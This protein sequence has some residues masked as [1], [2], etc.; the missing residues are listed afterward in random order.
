MLGSKSWDYK[1]LS[2]SL[3]GRINLMYYFFWGILTIFWIKD[4]YPIASGLIEK[5]PSSIGIPLTYIC[6]VVIIIDV[7]ISAL[8]VYRMS[9]RLSGKEQAHKVSNFINRKYPDERLKKIYPN[10]QFVRKNKVDFT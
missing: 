5:I 2:L 7:I 8:S 3:N 4:I 6:L 9:M 10:M 1:K